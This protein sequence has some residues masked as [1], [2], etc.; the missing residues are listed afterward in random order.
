MGTAPPL[1]ASPIRGQDAAED[2]PLSDCED[3]DQE[4]VDAQPDGE[5]RAIPM[6]VPD[7]TQEQEDAEDW[8]EAGDQ[9]DGVNRDDAEDRGDAEDQDD[10]PE[11]PEPTEPMDILFRGFCTMS[12][13]LSDVYG[14]A[15]GEIEILLWKNLATATHWDWNVV[16]GASRLIH[17]WMDRI[18][19]AMALS[20]QNT[21][22]HTRLLAKA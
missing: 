21:G 16:F 10:P 12:Q 19:P 22:E 9:G 5:Y 15:S 17:T 11:S 14:R 7:D 3:G 4:M 8:I 20:D 18:K 2:A 1:R 13:V 6:Q